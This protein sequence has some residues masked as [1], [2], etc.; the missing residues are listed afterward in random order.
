LLRR[1]RRCSLDGRL[2]LQPVIRRTHAS[3]IRISATALAGNSIGLRMLLLQLV[4]KGGRGLLHVRRRRCRALRLEPII[5]RRE[6][7]RHR[8]G[9]RGVIL[10]H[11]CLLLLRRLLRLGGRRSGGGWCSCVRRRDCLLWLR[12]RG[13]RQLS[14]RLLSCLHL[15]RRTIGWS[16]QPVICCAEV[17]A[18]IISRSR[19]SRCRLSDRGLQRF[20]GSRSRDFLSHRLRHRARR[21][22]RRQHLRRGMCSRR[23]RRRARG[24]RQRRS[25]SQARGGRQ[26]IV[27]RCRRCCCSRSRQC[28]EWSGTCCGC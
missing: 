10:H 28:S 6:V 11:Q 25:C 26:Q 13:G 20:D 12:L 8:R 19:S 7:V 24:R 15:S 17:V 22:Y 16:L 18:N 2:H 4:S 14:N 23:R 5:C 9:G 27:H 1:R 21:G 3:E